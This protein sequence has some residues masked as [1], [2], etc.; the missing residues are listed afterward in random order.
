MAANRPAVADN[1]FHLQIKEPKAVCFTLHPFPPGKPVDITVICDIL[2]YVCYT[3]LVNPT[4]AIT[5]RK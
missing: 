2:S 3:P 5:V 4:L 1:G